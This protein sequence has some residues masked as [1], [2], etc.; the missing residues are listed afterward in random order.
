MHGRALAQR[1]WDDGC[2]SLAF[3]SLVSML[4]AAQINENDSVATRE[5]FDSAPRAF[6]ALG[7]SAFVNDHVGHTDKD[8][9][10]GTS[11]KNPA[12]DFSVIMKAV[13][14]GRRGVSGEYELRCTKDRDA[15]LIGDKLTLDHKASDDGSFTYQSMGWETA[16][17]AD[18]KAK[19]NAP[20]QG[21]IEQFMAEIGRPVSVAEIVAETG[22]PT[23]AIRSALR[24]GTTGKN[25]KF[26]QVERGK[27]ALAE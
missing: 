27:Y 1:A 3:D 2:R 11:D 19:V 8:R 17:L 5:W 13:T 4:G 12:V 10:R 18:M 14:V 21:G 9:G 16:D 7:G 24:R 22:Q 23:E 15:R 6:V 20:R 25:R 26:T